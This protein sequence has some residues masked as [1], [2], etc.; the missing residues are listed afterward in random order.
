MGNALEAI[1]PLNLLP[2]V[3]GRCDHGHERN[4]YIAEVGSWVVSG[5]RRGVRCGEN[6][7]NE[8]LW[9]MYAGPKVLL[10]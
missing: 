6:G 8:V 4:I 2:V 10:L 3:R 1:N 9:V 7:C 5:T